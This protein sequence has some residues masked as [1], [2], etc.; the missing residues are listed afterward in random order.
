MPTR[1][2]PVYEVFNRSEAGTE[3]GSQHGA[4]NDGATLYVRR[5]LRETLGRSATQ[6]LKRQERRH[7]P[8]G[9][10]AH[11]VPIA[12]QV[13]CAARLDCHIPA[14]STHICAVAGMAVWECSIP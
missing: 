7:A 10:S 3:N 6:Q 2:A 12:P 1:N 11:S 5:H 8:A 14:G 13:A 9:T 4:P